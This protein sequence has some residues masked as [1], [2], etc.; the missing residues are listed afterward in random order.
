MADVY[1]LLFV[2]D[3]KYQDLTTEIIE[4]LILGT[5]EYM[6]FP[7]CMYNLP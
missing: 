7:H 5:Y 1:E 3:E 2:A 6:I 4:Y